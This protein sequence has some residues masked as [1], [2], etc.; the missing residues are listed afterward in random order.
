MRVLKIIA[1]GAVLAVGGCI[2][3]E[4]DTAILG[5][6][7]ARVSGFV[8]VPRGM[9]DMVGGTDGF[10][11]EEDGTLEM[12]ETHARCNMLTEGTFA[13]VFEAD[14]EGEPTPTATDLGD[15]TVR[16]VFPMAEFTDGMNEMTAEP[17]MVAMFRP[18]MEGHAVTLSISG[19]EIVS[20]NGML[21]EDG[22][23][24]SIRF[25]LTDLLEE[26]TGLPETFEA[27]VR[28]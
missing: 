4:M 14:T 2:D 22:T 11:A 17:E 21:S 28:Y 1:V 7:Q 9:L 6:D 16:V 23:R 5:P 24:A 12:T 20:T 25:D 15:G 8:Q 13:E 18:M 10:C 27:V 3:M 19:R 26:E